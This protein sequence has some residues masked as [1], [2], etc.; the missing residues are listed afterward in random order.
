M[1]ALLVLYIIVNMTDPIRRFGVWWS[2]CS[3]GGGG[4]GGGG[5][6]LTLVGSVQ[7][8]NV[9]AVDLVHSRDSSLRRVIPVV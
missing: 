1:L 3:G 7:P 9:N 5:H 8:G 6:A 4:G 2:G